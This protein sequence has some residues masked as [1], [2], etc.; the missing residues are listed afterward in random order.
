MTI[1]GGWQEPRRI[2]AIYGFDI[3]IEGSQFGWLE[4][5][6]LRAIVVQDSKWAA[7]F[8]YKKETRNGVF[9]E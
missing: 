7:F 3:R 5:D 6:L 2:R 8:G 1:R 9:Y 4:K